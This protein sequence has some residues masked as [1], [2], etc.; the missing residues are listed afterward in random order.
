MILSSFIFIFG[1]FK[2]FCILGC[3]IVID[4][5][6]L[7]TNNA[8]IRYAVTMITGANVKIFYGMIQCVEEVFD[9]GFNYIVKSFVN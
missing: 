8:L 5:V 6:V 9:T 3:S 4:N 7:K 1:A 2:T